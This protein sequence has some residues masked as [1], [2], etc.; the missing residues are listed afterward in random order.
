M[1]LTDVEA[2]RKQCRVVPAVGVQS[3]SGFT[4]VTPNCLGSECMSWRWSIHTKIENR[5]VEP[6][7]FCGM[8]TW[9]PR[10]VDMDMGDRPINADEVP[11]VAQPTIIVGDQ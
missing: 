11:G 3:N 6:I 2:K 10:K 4:F 9:G 7:G 1:L 5:R 8:V